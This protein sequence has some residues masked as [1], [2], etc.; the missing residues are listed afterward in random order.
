MPKSCIHLEKIES[1]VKKLNVEYSNNRWSRPY[2]P[3]LKIEYVSH[4][5]T[6][7][8]GT[9]ADRDKDACYFRP[10]MQIVYYRS[11]DTVYWDHSGSTSEY[12]IA[13]IESLKEGGIILN[14]VKNEIISIINEC[15]CESK[16]DQQ[17]VLARNTETDLV[18][19]RT[20]RDNLSGRVSDLQSSN[21]SLQSTNT[22]LSNQLVQKDKDI[23][24]G[25]K[26]LA[27]TQRDRDDYKNKWIVDVKRI[28]DSFNSL[29]LESNNKDNEIT[30]LR[31]ELEGSQNIDLRYRERKL[32][33]LV[34]DLGLNRERIDNLRSA[35]ERLKR[36]SDR[37]NYNQEDITVAQNEIDDIKR[38]L[39]QT[40]INIDDLHKV[41]KVCEKVAELR[42]KQEK[43]RQQQQQQYQ[44]HQEQPTN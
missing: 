8:S 11:G 7:I 19:V 10:G 36:A 28:T 43:I 13:K 21:W 16:N 14:G 20:E 27:R 1:I 33:G 4:Q 31:E 30:S 42:I 22:S 23:E 34:R 44:A 40:N 17:L 5:A 39:F 37:E 26:E 15:N 6:H 29:K 2:G 3:C 18:R 35:Y 9:A 25:K 41:Y 38:E 32:D 12:I 24:W